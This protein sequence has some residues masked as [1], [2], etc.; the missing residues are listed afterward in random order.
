MKVVHKDAIL[1]FRLI[2]QS[3]KPSDLSDFLYRVEGARFRPQFRQSTN[4]MEN[5][6]EY[7]GTRF[8]STINFSKYI[9]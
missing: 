4:K 1:P 3:W 7:I 6:D 2:I 9:V 8:S 5:I